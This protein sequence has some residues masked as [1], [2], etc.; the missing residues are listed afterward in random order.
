[1]L[2]SEMKIYRALMTLCV[3]WFIF[4]CLLSFFSARPFWLDENYM[5]ENIKDLGYKQLLG[6][7]KSSEASPRIYLIVSK[8]IGEKFNY[9]VLSLRFL[10][11]L[12][13]LIAFFIWEKIYKRVFS[14]SWHFLLALSAFAGSHYMSYYAAEF[15]HY[16]TDVLVVGAF[17]LYLFHQKEHLEKGLTKGFIAAT[18]LLPLALLFSYG[19]FFVFWIVGYNFLFFIKNNRRALILLIVYGLMCLLFLIFI[20]CCD[21]KHTLKTIPLLEYWRDYFLC[22]DSFSCFIKPFG[23][24]LRR[25]SVWW[26]GTSFVYRRAASVFIPFFVFSLFGYGFKS[27]LRNKFKLWE[28]DAL[29]LVIFLELFVLGIMKKYPFTGERITL[30]FAPF[31]FYFTVKGIICL[32]KYKPLYWGINFYYVIFIIVCNINSFRIFLNFYK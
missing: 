23:E 28:I 16:S 8:Y 24:G 25:L 19:A 32:K 3:A 15:K 14:S 20:F 11:L 4:L 13:M 21:I 1:M 29:G 6:P 2:S 18:C 5:L 12:S 31:V 27:L 30:F 9:A 22:T 26:Y 17:C 7:L 10:P